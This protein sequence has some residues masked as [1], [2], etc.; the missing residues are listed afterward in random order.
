MKR[1]TGYHSEKDFTDLEIYQAEQTAKAL[2]C[3]FR[4]E[5]VNLAP[6]WF[7]VGGFLFGSALLYVFYNLA[8]WIMGL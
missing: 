5:P 6:I 1:F 7:F 8:D 2:K 4:K 3:G